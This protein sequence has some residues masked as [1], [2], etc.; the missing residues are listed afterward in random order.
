MI[1]GEPSGTLL[2]Y[3]SPEESA[4]DTNIVVK[5]SVVKMSTSI[6]KVR[7]SALMPSLGGTEIA[8]KWLSQNVICS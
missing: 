7:S 5:V 6:A 1:E 3:R 8:K 4:F 2:R